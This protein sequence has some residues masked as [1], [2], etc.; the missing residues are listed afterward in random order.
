MWLLL[1]KLIRKAQTSCGVNRTFRLYRFIHAQLLV[2]R[3]CVASITW[4]KCTW[5]KKNRTQSTKLLFHLTCA[6][7]LILLSCT[8][9]CYQLDGVFVYFFGFDAN[10]SNRNRCTLCVFCI[11]W[12]PEKS[13]E[14]KGKLFF[15]GK[16]MLNEKSFLIGNCEWIVILKKKFF[17]VMQWIGTKIFELA[18]RDAF[19]HMAVE[20]IC[21]KNHSNAPHNT[22]KYS[23][24]LT[25]SRKTNEAHKKLWRFP[26][27]HAFMAFS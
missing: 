1:V 23:D 6:S 8:N 19:Y 11:Q 5:T 15:L 10:R 14:S 27:S 20:Q 21:L 3:I 2:N 25:Q 17:F 13:K 4:N 7:H 16:K 22:S 9:I 12:T 26:F 24:I 18:K